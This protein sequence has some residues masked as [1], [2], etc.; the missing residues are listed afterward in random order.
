MKD[1]EADILLL[2]LTTVIFIHVVSIIGSL[3]LSTGSTA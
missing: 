2:A 1:Y 3:S